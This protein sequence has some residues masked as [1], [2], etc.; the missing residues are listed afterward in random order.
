MP[1]QF[2]IVPDTRKVWQGNLGKELLH[3]A[4]A[5]NLDHFRVSSIFLPISDIWDCLDIVWAYTLRA[6]QFSLLACQ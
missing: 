1:L 2:D 3:P 5:A 4:T 6:Q